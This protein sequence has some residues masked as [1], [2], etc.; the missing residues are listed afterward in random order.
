M[1]QLIFC[2]TLLGTYDD[3]EFVDDDI[4]QYYGFIPSDFLSKDKT[5]VTAGFDK[6]QGIFEFYDVNGEIVESH[7]LKVSV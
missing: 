5:A 2:G 3:W 7:Q 1:N 6:A 4:H